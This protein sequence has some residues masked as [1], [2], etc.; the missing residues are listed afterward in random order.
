MYAR[1]PNLGNL[2]VE[3]LP[4]LESEVGPIGPLNVTYN[5][6]HVAALYTPDGHHRKFGHS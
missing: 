4:T 6:Y 3:L 5:M 1:D 2:S